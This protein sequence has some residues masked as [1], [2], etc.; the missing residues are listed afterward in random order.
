MLYLDYSRAADEWLPNKYGGREN[1][2]AID[3]L[4]EMNLQTHTQYQGIMTIAEESTAWGGVTRPVYAE[5]LGF[6]M[7]WNMGWMN[8]TL[9]YFKKDPVYRRYHHNLLTFSLCYAFSENFVLPISHDEIVHGKG[10]GKLRTG[11]HA[12]LKTHPHVKSFRMGSFG[13]GEM[14]VTVVTIK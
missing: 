7:K 14:G 13:E 5:G 12:F 6:S 1:L 4:K 2:E 11:I 3:F 9:S 8:D 10:T